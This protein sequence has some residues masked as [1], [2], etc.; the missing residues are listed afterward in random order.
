[1]NGCAIRGG[2]VDILVGFERR[3]I[4]SGLQVEQVNTIE[5]KGTQ[6]IVNEARSYDGS[7]AGAVRLRGGGSRRYEMRVLQVLSE[8][9]RK[10]LTFGAKCPSKSF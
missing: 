10:L 5:L 1:M 9:M 4:D 6:L 3:G 7:L 2:L 8:C